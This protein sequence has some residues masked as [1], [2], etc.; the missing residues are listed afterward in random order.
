M[1]EDRHS[2]VLH[3]DIFEDLA[4]VDIP[5]SLVVPHLGGQQDGAENDALPVARTN[6]HLSICQKPFQVDLTRVHVHQFTPA[7][8]TSK[9]NSNKEKRMGVFSG[10]LSW[11]P[12]AVNLPE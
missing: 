3:C 7:I 11:K 5:H 10:L 8:H 12:G 4:V 9:Q 6:V 2:H 1:D